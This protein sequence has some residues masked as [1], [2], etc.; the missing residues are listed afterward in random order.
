MAA[1]KL[2]SRKTKKRSSGDQIKER[3]IKQLVD[4]LRDRGTHVRREKL[5]RG[6]GYKVASGQCRLRSD[7]TLVLDRSLPAEEQITFLSNFVAQKGA[8]KSIDDDAEALLPESVRDYI[9]KVRIQS[10]TENH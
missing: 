5:P 9:K 10:S 2:S 6:I 3:I 1:V 7:E 8:P 4:I